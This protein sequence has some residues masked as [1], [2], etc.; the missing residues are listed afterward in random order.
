MSSSSGRSYPT[1]SEGDEGSDEETSS[2]QSADAF[3]WSLRDYLS[4]VTDCSGSIIGRELFL[5]QYSHAPQ[6]FINSIP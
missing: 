1:L 3:E 6:F 2:D 5:S 4:N